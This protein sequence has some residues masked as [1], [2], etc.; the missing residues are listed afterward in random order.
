MNIKNQ[1]QSL[2][3]WSLRI[4][5]KTQKFFHIKLIFSKL[6]EKKQQYPTPSEQIVS[7]QSKKTGF[8]FIQTTGSLY[9]S[10]WF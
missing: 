1:K 10:N 6:P 2:T 9:L 8:T 4:N 7:I 3:N 5:I